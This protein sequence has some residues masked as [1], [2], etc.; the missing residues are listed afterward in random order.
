MHKSYPIK[1]YLVGYGSLMSHDSRYR[2][3]GIDVRGIPVEV[4]GWHR[5]WNMSSP[6]ENI[7]CVGALPDHSDVRLNGMLVQVAEI[8]DKLR[9]REQNYHF[10]E[11]E[12]DELDIHCE[13]T[14]HRLDIHRESIKVW[15][16]QVADPQTSKDTHPICQSYVDTCL[17]GCLE[18]K[19]E[20]FAMQ[21]IEQ[22]AG[23]DGHWLNDRGNP[24][25]PR[26]AQVATRMQKQIDSLLEKVGIIHY[27]K[28]NS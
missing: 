11:L 8:C 23:W 10:I 27:R 21:F 22:T 26:A 28:E 3:N 19:D 15:I 12:L 16:C 20:Q 24:R 14:S 4:S 2:Y 9:K 1:H 6:G 7:T 18:H 17:S 5:A 25:Y 13:S